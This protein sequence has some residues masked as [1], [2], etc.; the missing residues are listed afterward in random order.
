M[1]E[2]KDAEKIVKTHILWSLGAG[3]VPIPVMDILAVTAIQLDMIKQLCRFYG[4][5]YSESKGKS[6]LSTLTGSTLARLGASAVK[7]L[8]GVGTL[9]GSVTMPVLS[10]ASTYAIGQVVIWHFGAGG[11]LFDIDFSNIKEVY[12]ENL[13][14][15]KEIA[16]QFLN[17]RKA[18]ASSNDETFKKLERLLQLKE[19]GLITEEE[20]ETKKQQLLD[21]L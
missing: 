16:Q 17:K 18:A 15:G 13:K 6:I 3:L 20:F 2:H 11:N 5:D 4:M 21:S 12:K 14:K 7:T 9:I 19:Q 10:G 1:D 8:P